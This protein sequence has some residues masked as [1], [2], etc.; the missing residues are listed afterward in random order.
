MIQEP[1][2]RYEL[3]Q[4]IAKSRE[5]FREWNAVTGWPYPDTG[6]YFEFLAILDDAVIRGW[7]A[8]QAIIDELQTTVTLLEG[9][10]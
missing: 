6:F 7:D 4:A 8:Q 5:K 10:L 2:R 3:H 9:E 1:S